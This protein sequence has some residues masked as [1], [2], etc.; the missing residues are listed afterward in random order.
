M[1][2]VTIT[3]NDKS[4]APKALAN[5]D[6]LPRCRCCGEPYDRDASD[7]SDPDAYCSSAC[8]AGDLG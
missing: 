6:K 8:E 4:H 5:T 1:Q 2:T 3:Q 7:A